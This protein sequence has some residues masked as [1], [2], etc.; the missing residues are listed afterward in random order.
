MRYAGIIE[1]VDV[2]NFVDTCSITVRALGLIESRRASGNESYSKLRTSADALHA[3]QRNFP[4]EINGI[5]EIV[6]R[7]DFNFE[8]KLDAGTV[9]ATLL[10]LTRPLF[11]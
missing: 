3:A 5:F 2:L 4:D 6:R 9:P 10:R 8:T 11:K 1:T 7:G